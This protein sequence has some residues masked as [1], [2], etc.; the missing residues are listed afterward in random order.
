[1]NPRI[2]AAAI[3]AVT[4]AL[5]WLHGQH[6]TVWLSGHPVTMPAAIPFFAAVSALI[7]AGAWLIFRRLSRDG[8]GVIL[9]TYWR[10]VP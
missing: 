9:T 4:V 5:A 8:Y 2:L 3:T 6:V 1:M 10:A 7:A